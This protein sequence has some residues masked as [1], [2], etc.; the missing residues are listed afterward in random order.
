MDQDRD[1]KGFKGWM[2][3]KFDF[4]WIYIPPFSLVFC[5]GF[6]GEAWF[7]AVP[8]FYGLFPTDCPAAVA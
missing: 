4:N 7:A 2:D 6:T 3:K 8:S 5:V 1:L